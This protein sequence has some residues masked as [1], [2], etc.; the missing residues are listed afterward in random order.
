[1][2]NISSHLQKGCKLPKM[3]SLLILKRN[4]EYPNLLRL[5]K[6]V[7]IIYSSDNFKAQLR[8]AKTMGSARGV[9]MIEEFR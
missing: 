9:L 2:G 7:Q 4:F 6:Q 3:Y 5:V 1:M 8:C